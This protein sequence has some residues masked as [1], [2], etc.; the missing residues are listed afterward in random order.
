MAIN[1]QSITA[2]ETADS[3]GYTVELSI[4]GHEMSLSG[5]HGTLSAIE[6]CNAIRSG[7]YNVGR[8]S[9]QPGAIVVDTSAH[10]GAVAISLAKMHPHIT[11][12]ACEPITEAYRLLVDNI[13]RNQVSNVIAVN[14]AIRSSTG[15]VDL[16]WK[17]DHYTDE[18]RVELAEGISLDDLFAEY[19]IERSAW[20][21]VVSDAS[22]DDIFMHSAAIGRVDH[23]EIDVEVLPWNSMPWCSNYVKDAIMAR[24]PEALPTAALWPITEARW[25]SMGQLA[26]WDKTIEILNNAMQI[27]KQA[28]LA[29]RLDDAET[30]YREISNAFPGYAQAHWNLGCVLGHKEDYEN[31]CHA[32]LAASSNDPGLSNVE[33]AYRGH[34]LRIGDVPG[35]V[36]AALVMLEMKNNPY[37]INDL[38][39]NPGDTI[40]DIGGNVGMI[41]IAVAKLHPDVRIIAFEPSKT[42]FEHLVRNLRNNG[43]TNV[44][45]VNKAVSDKSGTMHLMVNASGFGAS[46]SYFDVD[47]HVSKYQTEAW[48]STFVAC[49]SLEDIFAT[50]NIDRCRWIKLDCEGGEYEIL[51][52]CDVLNRVD[53]IA[54][55]LHT[56]PADQV[57]ATVCFDYITNSIT[58]RYGGMP[59]RLTAT[60]VSDAQWLPLL[61]RL[62]PEALA[63]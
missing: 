12:I 56:P 5:G 59:C 45:P 16:F 6:A 22:E 18:R 24:E 23:F 51:C 44:I 4:A 2:P 3:P 62:M 27:G 54:M 61:Q 13:A 28:V 32:Y 47:S 19:G 42:K 34:I 41:S 35:S 48:T 26:Q 52:N 9:F 50:Y 25:K 38:D 15:P 36:D 58:A 1:T 11:V 63:A 37:G 14:K 60:A 31:A 29:N 57:D 10:I 7:R 17:P 53:S 39:L 46:T 43:I 40:L 33:F 49:M 8:T 55:E 20:T 30:I 21:K